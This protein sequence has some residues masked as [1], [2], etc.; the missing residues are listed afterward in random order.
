MASIALKLAAG[1]LAGAA[2]GVAFSPSLRADSPAQ[3]G[4]F[5]RPADPETIRSKLSIY[6]SPPAPAVLVPVKSPLQ[7]EVASAR[8]A[9]TD[10]LDRVKSQTEDARSTWLSWEKRGEQAVKS[11]VSDKDQLN[12]NAFYVAVSTLAGSIIGRNRILLRL[13]LPPVFLLAS[14]SY[15]LPNS[16]R[17]ISAHLGIPEQYRD[18]KGWVDAQAR[19]AEGVKR[20]VE[21]KRRV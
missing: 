21:E 12:P 13:T 7:D 5:A 4:A 9:A 6:D 14:T 17:L 18:V 10:V 15:F 3:P 8:L 19:K 2:A 20:E 16:W 1:G 11:V